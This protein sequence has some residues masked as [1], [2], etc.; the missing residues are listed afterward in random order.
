MCC[1]NSK[2]ILV[3]DDSSDNQLLMKLILEAQGYS[4]R[5]AGSGKDGLTEIKKAIPDLII[6]DLMMPDM[7]GLD[8]I[9]NLKDNDS[10]AKIPILLCTAHRYLDLKDANQ[11]DNV[12]YKP[13]DIDDLLTKINNLI[14]CCEMP[15]RPTLSLDVDAR[16]PLHREHQELLSTWQSETSSLEILRES[17]YEIV[18]FQNRHLR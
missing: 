17:G 3:I 10:S 7:S 11:A 4:F 9:A 15:P 5:S 6:L 16:D 12:C 2:N 14:V 18:N 13:F 1:S 8:V